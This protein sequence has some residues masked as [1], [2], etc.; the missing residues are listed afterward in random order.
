MA[1]QSTTF[2]R[3]AIA[4]A[5]AATAMAFT[6]STAIA[7]ANAAPK[8]TESGLRAELKKAQERADTLIKEYNAKRVSLAEAR[9]AEETALQSLTEAQAAYDVAASR[10]ARI[11]QLRYQAGSS[12]LMGLVTAPDFGGAAV[13]EQIAAEEAADF[14]G[15]AA[16]RDRRRTATETAA[17]ITARIKAETA[18]VDKQREEALD[19]ID[20]IEKKLDQLVP[21]GPGRRA[22]GSWVPQL[23]TGSDNVTARTR[24]MRD[25][26]TRR[27]DL[28]YDVGCYR[29]DTSGEHPLGRACDFMLSS[30]GA[31][32]S[33]EQ[34]ALGD[35]M[36]TWVIK[37]GKKLGLKYVI[38]KQRIYN[39]SY[40]GWRAMNDRGSTTENHYDH[41][42]ISMH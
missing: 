20:D 38:Y 7:P 41:V 19:L 22:D 27:F 30:G 40:P 15:Y 21:E 39:M 35:E 33:A 9:A 6:L 36:A 18:E 34:A 2:R 12:G 23:P 1:A 10:V 26:I 16:A 11:V 37:N 25:Q 5:T 4:A 32:P 13:M 28:G 8:P 31:M 24:T 14:S 42:H 29:V 3:H 17:T